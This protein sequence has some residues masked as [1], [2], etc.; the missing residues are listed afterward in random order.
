MQ[1]FFDIFFKL[2][3]FILGERVP[4]GGSILQ[5]RT[6]KRVICCFFTLFFVL[7]VSPNVP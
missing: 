1:P 2:E 5:L 7:N 3:R 6:D 4:Y